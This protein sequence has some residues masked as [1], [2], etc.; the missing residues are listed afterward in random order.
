MII[1]VVIIII[2]IV[3]TIVIVIV[4]IAVIDYC[5]RVSYCYDDV[6]VSCLVVLLLAVVVCCSLLFVVHCGLFF[7]VVALF[8][9]SRVTSCFAA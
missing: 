7:T 9:T 8:V 4:I 5:D 1:V 2:V 6:D 3:I